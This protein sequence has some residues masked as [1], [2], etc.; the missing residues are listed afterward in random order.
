MKI[1]TTSLGGGLWSG[2]D[3]TLT[4]HGELNG[5]LFSRNI[6]SPILFSLL[7][8]SFFAKKHEKSNFQYL[9]CGIDL[10]AFLPTKLDKAKLGQGS[11]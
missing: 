4:D 9:L 8:I 3:E 1:P 7:V 2:Y 10:V 11:G 5:I 6:I